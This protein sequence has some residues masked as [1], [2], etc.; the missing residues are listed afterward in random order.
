MCADRELEVAAARVAGTRDAKTT[1]AMER[2]ERGLIFH[3]GIMVRSSLAVRALQ[4][5]LAV[6]GAIYVLLGVRLI[7]IYVGVTPSADFA[8]P[9]W[10]A[11]DPLYAPF[12]GAFQPG[13]DGA[14]HRLEWSL[15]AAIASYAVVHVVSRKLVLVASRPRA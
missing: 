15:V 6:F 13:D 11:T 2:I 3:R 1:H 12:Q 9:L 8:Q 7:L 10:Q 5:M 4:L 14:G